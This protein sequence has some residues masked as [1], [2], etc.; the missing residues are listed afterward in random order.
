MA[1]KTAPWSL[2]ALT[3]PVGTYETLIEVNA[4]VAGS[5]VAY[6]LSVVDA[7]VDFAAQRSPRVHA[8]VTIA[9]PASSVRALLD[10][11]FGLEIEILAGYRFFASGHED[12][13]RMCRLRVQD[14]VTDQADHTIT[15]DADSDEVVAIG[16][17]ID[18]AASYTTS[19]RIYNGIRDLI[20]G[21]FPNEAPIYVVDPKVS[22]FVAFADTQDLSPGQDRWSFIQDWADSIGAVVYHDGLGYWHIDPAEPK[23]SAFT[24]ANLKTGNRGTIINVRTMES[25]NGFANRAAAVYEYAVGTANYRQ[26]AVAGTTLYPVSMATDVKR[27]KPHNAG[28]VARQ[29][30]YRGLRRGHTVEVEAASFLWVRPG[31]TVTA[32][33]P[34][35]SQ[36]RLLVETASFNLTEG[37]MTLTGQNADGA[38]FSTITTTVT[39][40]TL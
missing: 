16:Y 6:P 27:F 37:T 17:P 39:T 7:S 11:R 1:E 24:V 26:T 36:E 28:E 10:P 18:A 25:R 9:W 13:Q 5:T 31:Q 4:Y 29:M 20:D 34:D 30:L 15:I 23:P 14:V 22:K 12:V 33:L 35:R 38:P 8:S 19:S 2:E 3:S 32:D 40:T 21:A